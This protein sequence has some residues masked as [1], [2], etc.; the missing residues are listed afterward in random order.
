VEVA[1]LGRP[2]KPTPPPT[3]VE[4]EV[5]VT[6]ARTLAVVASVR[7]A[8]D[9]RFRIDVPAGAYELQVFERG[10]AAGPPLH[11]DAGGERMVD[12]TVYFDTGVR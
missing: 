4:A 12:V 7:S 6:D 10:E 8:A 1:P 11:V 2:D 3:P 9:G 5:R